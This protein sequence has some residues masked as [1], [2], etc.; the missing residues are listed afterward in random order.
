MESQHRYWL[1]IMVVLTISWCGDKALTAYVT[2]H[3][4]CA[5]ADAGA[6]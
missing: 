6:P 4:P 1:A 3:K 2:I 5:G